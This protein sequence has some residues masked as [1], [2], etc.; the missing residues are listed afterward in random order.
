MQPHHF[1]LNG[2]LLSEAP[3]WTR[4][5]RAVCHIGKTALPGRMVNVGDGGRTPDP[6]ERLPAAMPH[7]PCG[8]AQKHVR[9][10]EAGEP[11]PT[12]A[13]LLGH[14]DAARFQGRDLAFSPGHLWSWRTCF[15]ST[16]V[17]SPAPRAVPRM[18]RMEK[19]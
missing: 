1:H 4:R 3:G 11:G 2:R 6:R 7:R 12:V 10:K 15:H 18:G 14:R 8:D 13:S 9:V 16:G 17:H 5:T 19:L